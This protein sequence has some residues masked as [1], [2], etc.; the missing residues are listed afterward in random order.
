MTT[1]SLTIIPYGKQPFTVG[2]LENDGRQ[3]GMEKIVQK[4]SGTNSVF[5][6]LSY[7]LVLN[8][9]NIDRVHSVHVYINDAYEP[10]TYSHGKIYFPDRATS[11]RRIFS[12]CYGYVEIS[13]TLVMD[14][15]NEYN[16]FTDY[17]SVL[18]RRGQLNNAVKSM[19]D[20]VDKHQEHLLLNGVSKPRD[21]AGLKEQGY[22]S[23]SAQ[24]ILAEEIASVYEG[25]YG[26]FKAN[27]RFRIEKV[28]SIDRLEHLQQVT[29]KTLEYIVSHP[30]ELRPVTSTSGVRIDGRVYQPQKTLS[31]RN[32]NSYDLYENRVILNFLRKMIDEVEVLRDECGTL[33]QQI[34]TDE[35]YSPDYIY[36]SFFIL[37]E[38][39]KRLEAN[40]RK[41]SQLY[42]RFV[43]LFGLYSQVLKKIRIEPLVISPKPTAIFL[44]V[45][46]YNKIFVRIH[47]WFNFGIYDFAK[48]NFML[49]FIKISSL[50]ESYLLA[51]L[52]NYL[53]NRG[54]TLQE[55]K[56]CTY[57][58]TSPNWKYK[59]TRGPNTFTFAKQAQRIRLYYQPVIYS[60]DRR[61]V[62]GIGLY[63]N[64][65]IPVAEDD[66]A[67]KRR[68]DCY[69]SPDYLI[70]VEENDTRKYLIL[71]AKFSDFETVRRKQMKNLAFKYLFS[72]SPI[73]STD[74][75]LGLGIIYGKCEDGE[76]LQSAYNKE[77]APNSIV[78]VADILPLI[79]GIDNDHH[80]T[81]LDR[82]FKNLIS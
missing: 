14:D 34:P 18:V 58:A 63:R 5:S 44:T 64:N 55:A 76:R 47:Q 41:L 38:T 57:P 30:E 45:P 4:S 48:E 10:S 71:D 65:S 19:V 1:C 49:S 2:L 39:R 20:Y 31:L 3:A 59:N 60:S 32:V 36:S 56:K 52:I 67:E 25:N 70:E 62:N 69:Y 24:V 16:L 27:C 43:T 23:L 33:L 50:Y 66:Y 53:G 51:K 81:K 9:E 7:E 82:F 74:S 68:G 8:Y 12:D 6:D 77:L 37:S 15:G 75:V 42:D 73:L 79:E 78:P 17:L 80:Y 28:P 26:Y 54:Y 21:L 11:D 35:D 61:A 46:Q 13:L 40:I 72:I 22:K 29:P